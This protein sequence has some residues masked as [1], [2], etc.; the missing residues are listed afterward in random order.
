MTLGRFK[1]KK[2]RLVLDRIKITSQRGVLTDPAGNQ[3]PAWAWLVQ[4]PDGTSRQTLHWK[5][6]RSYAETWRKP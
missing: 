2:E 4:F 5:F 1:F 3:R 6:A